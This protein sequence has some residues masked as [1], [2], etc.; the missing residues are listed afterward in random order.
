MWQFAEPFSSLLSNYLSLLYFGLFL[1]NNRKFFKVILELFN[2]SFHLLFP[3]KDKKN[4]NIQKI[5]F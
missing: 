2:D 1:F 5:D 4:L 3:E